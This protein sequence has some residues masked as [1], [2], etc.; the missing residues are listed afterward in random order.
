[1]SANAS[2]PSASIKPSY[3]QTVIASFQDT[4]AEVKDATLDVEIY[5]PGGQTT[6]PSVSLKPG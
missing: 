5:N 3:M 4:R 1:M 6:V 2:V